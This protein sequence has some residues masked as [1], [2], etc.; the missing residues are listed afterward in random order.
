MF[1]STFE[2]YR[3]GVCLR[4]NLPS[5]W[6][7][8]PR[9]ECSLCRITF[10]GQGGYLIDLQRDPCWKYKC[11]IS[12][13]SGG[14]GIDPNSEN[15]SQLIVLSRIAYYWWDINFSSSTRYIL[16]RFWMISSIWPRFWA[17]WRRCSAVGWYRA[18]NNSRKSQRTDLD[19]LGV[20]P[21]G[22]HQRFVALFLTPVK[23]VT[24]FGLLGFI[25]VSSIFSRC[26][27]S[28]IC[29]SSIFSRN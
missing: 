9:V 28:F 14:C 16:V 20:T 4:W 18:D 15:C 13:K 6:A 17:K 3:S 21:P 22:I 11:A 25:C 5:P 26:S 7:T 27:R 29:V 10:S 1:S 23:V 24:I 12:G 2:F 19:P 8:Y